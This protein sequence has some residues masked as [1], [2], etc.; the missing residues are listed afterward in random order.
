MARK[1]NP[2][3]Y[4]I[5]TRLPGTDYVV[6]KQLAKG[7]TVVLEVLSPA[8]ARLV[9][10]LVPPAI[11]TRKDLRQRF[12]DEARV[13]A[14]LDHPN[15][16]RVT[17]FNELDDG[18]PYFVMDRLHG[19]SVRRLLTK[20][21]TIQPAHLHQIMVGLLQALEHAHTRTPSIVHRDVKSENVFIHVTTSKDTQIKVLDFGLVG[22]N[23]LRTDDGVTVGTPGF[24]APEQLRGEAVTTKADLYSA[25]LIL[26]EGLAG[27]GPF[28]DVKL[29]PEDGDDLVKAL[30]RAHIQLDPP[31]LREFVPWVP[32]VINELVQSALAKNPDDRP[33]SALAFASKLSSLEFLQGPSRGTR[34]APVATPAEPESPAEAPRVP[35]TVVPDAPGESEA[36]EPP[37][38]LEEAHPLEIH[39]A[40]PMVE[41]A[42][43]PART[44]VPPA[45]REWPRPAVARRFRE[46][47]E[48]EVEYLWQRLRRLTDR[49][50]R[51]AALYSRNV[52]ARV[53]RL[54]QSA[55]FAFSSVHARLHDDG[56]ALVRPL[57]AAAMPECLRPR[58]AST[59]LQLTKSVDAGGGRY[60]AR[61]GEVGVSFELMWP[62]HVAAVLL[63]DVRVE[64]VHA[65]AQVLRMTLSTRRGIVLGTV[66]PDVLRLFLRLDRPALALDV[67]HALR[68]SGEAIRVVGYDLKGQRSIDTTLGP[69]ALTWP[70]IDTD[71]PG[72]SGAPVDRFGSSTLLRD[73]YAFPESFC[74]FDLKLDGLRDGTLARV[75]LTLPLASIVG[76][77]DD[78]SHDHVLLSCGPATNAYEATIEPLR[79]AGDR[80]QWPLRVAGRPHAEVIHIS[81]MRYMDPHNVK[82]TR[83]I[84][85]WEAP[86]LPN[87][88]EPGSVYYLVEQGVP[89]GDGPTALRVS[90]ATGEGFERELPASIVEGSVVASDGELTDVLGLGDV[91]RAQAATNVTRVTRSRR[92][93]SGEN[94]AW[95]MNAYARM[96]PHRLVTPSYLNEFFGLHDASDVR[97]ETSRIAIPHFTSAKHDRVHRLVDGMLEWGDA[98]SVTLDTPHASVGETWLLHELLSR[99]I[100][101]RTE[102]ARFSTLSATH[103]STQAEFGVRQGVRLP[104]PLG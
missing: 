69:G 31:S 22:G 53:T 56:Q 64:R 59:I 29:T 57:V 47:F 12:F 82:R 99:A 54:V 50:P 72:L 35:P 41:D 25:A 38:L 79:P 9:V 78:L 45:P 91:G 14:Q 67:I 89:A 33:D 70:R 7:D 37:V 24:S 28:D 40:E 39:E 30:C 77:V 16:V 71:E 48:R 15:V 85:S 18:T 21:T 90:F 103:G 13:L 62:V 98:F 92:A 44:P 83:D 102:L 43:E 1:A 55:A 75:E 19:R 96:P 58:P 65:A 17:D 80:T 104:F 2:Q 87:S 73:L 34:K 11:A 3:P 74:F 4:P 76:G 100:A 32:K 86:L 52:D 23:L 60:S 68:S 66:L 36:A 81:R 49:Y 26:Y 94:Y 46:Q 63:S 61:S 42:R 10:K 101:E 51:L 84:I 6:V 97:D 95:R 8:E 5:G 93:P 27:R 88:F 20:T